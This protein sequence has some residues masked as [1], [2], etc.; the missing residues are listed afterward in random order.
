M[1]TLLKKKVDVYV[2]KY[3]AKYYFFWGKSDGA[4]EKKR[5]G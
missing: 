5:K 4:G 1:H 3:Y 2:S